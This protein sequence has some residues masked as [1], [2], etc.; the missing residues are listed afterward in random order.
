MELTPDRGPIEVKRCL[1]G[2]AFRDETCDLG[3]DL[4][5]FWQ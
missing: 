5:E 2:E 4:T 3:F 1:G